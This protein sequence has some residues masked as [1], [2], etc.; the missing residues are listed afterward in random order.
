MGSK[1]NNP[2][3]AFRDRDL[4]EELAGILAA[5][6]IVSKR[7]ARKLLALKCR[8]ESNDEGSDTDEQNE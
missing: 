7:L 6:S 4:D 1:A 5:I 8:G 2:D 3:T